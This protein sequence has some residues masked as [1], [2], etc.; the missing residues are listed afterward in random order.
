VEV[1]KIFSQIAKTAI[2]HE[3]QWHY[4]ESH[5]NIKPQALFAKTANQFSIFFAYQPRPQYSKAFEVI[6]PLLYFHQHL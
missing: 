3:S 6:I 2:N 4:I 1:V 5:L